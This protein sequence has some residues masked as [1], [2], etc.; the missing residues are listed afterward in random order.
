ME[1]TPSDPSELRQYIEVI[2]VFADEISDETLKSLYQQS[3]N[4][5]EYWEKARPATLIWSRYVP[6]SSRYLCV[7]ST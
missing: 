3:V 1:E 5:L 4:L 7:P 6:N 2:S